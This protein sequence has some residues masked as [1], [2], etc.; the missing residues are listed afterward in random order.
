MEVNIHPYFKTA[1]KILVAVGML[2]VIIRSGHLDLEVLGQLFMNPQSALALLA[3]A[4]LNILFL[5]LRWWILIT[6]TLKPFS[7]IRSVQLNLIG[8][9][10]NFVIP[11]SIGGDV[12]R[13]YYLAQDFQDEKMKS[14]L[15]VVV[16]RIVGL[17]S[18]ISLSFFSLVWISFYRSNSALQMLTWS[19]V[20]LFLVYTLCL[21]ILISG[22]GKKILNQIT[23]I[24]LHK[25]VQFLLSCHDYV[26]GCLRRPS[27]FFKIFFVGLFSQI[28]VVLFFYVVAHFIG[29]QDV[30][31]LDLVSVIPLGFLAM[32][33][34]IAP[35]GIG[36]GQMAY[37]FLMKQVTG[38]SSELGPTA[39]SAFQIAL[40]IW[41][42]GGGW[43]YLTLK[44]PKELEAE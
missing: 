8:N 14:A 3:L 42:L 24:Y 28:F 29:E 13:G 35:A 12:L 33:V 31:I 4:A 20:V 6:Q 25:P 41:S 34:P 30:K 5:T 15:T 10:F 11:S 43:F 18:L 23:H 1:L 27:L 37:L 21:L 17:Y 22:F 16:D 26:S 7:F 19:V 39:I 32:S 36:V 44:K 40:L 2:W 38:Q 9:F